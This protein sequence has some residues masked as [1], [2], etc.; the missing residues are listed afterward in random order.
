MDLPSDPDF[1]A[2]F[3]FLGGIFIYN[4][5][6]SENEILN[7]FAISANWVTIIKFSAALLKWVAK[8]FHCF[9]VTVKLQR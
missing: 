8:K 7:C 6:Y 1:F 4:T 3:S 2:A 9:L 5:L